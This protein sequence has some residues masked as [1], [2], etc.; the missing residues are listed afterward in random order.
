MLE[1]AKGAIGK[2]I[3]KIKKPLLVFLMLLRNSC[4]LPY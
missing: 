3:D 4:Y 2:V 1:S